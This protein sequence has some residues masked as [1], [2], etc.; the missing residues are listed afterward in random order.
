MNIFGSH[1][2]DENLEDWTKGMV[3]RLMAPHAARRGRLPYQK[4]RSLKPP[5]GAQ[6]GAAAVH[7][8]RGFGGSSP[9]H[10]LSLIF[11]GNHNSEKNGTPLAPT[12]PPGGLMAHAMPPHYLNETFLTKMFSHNRN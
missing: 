1:P 10:H 11:M 6:T 7:R 2:N 4:F 9:H 12:L 3:P 8:K 5:R